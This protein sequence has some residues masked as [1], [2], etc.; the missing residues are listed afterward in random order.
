MPGNGKDYV[1][2]DAVS[3]IN[4]IAHL[5]NRMSRRIAD[6]SNDI[7]RNVLPKMKNGKFFALQVY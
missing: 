2:E 4:K 7:E 6:F 3:D 1:W 5:D